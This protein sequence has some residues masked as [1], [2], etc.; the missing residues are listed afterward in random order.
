MKKGKI[1]VYVVFRGL[2]KGNYVLD[3]T[4]Y[5]PDFQLVPKTEE[6]LYVEAARKVPPPITRIIPRTVEMPPLMKVYYRCFCQ[7]YFVCL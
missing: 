6:H 1:S 7:L 2:V 5:K 3:H 4:A